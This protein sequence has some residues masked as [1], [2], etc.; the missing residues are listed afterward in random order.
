MKY[1]N[2]LLV[3]TVATACAAES[4]PA[5]TQTSQHHTFR[6]V[7]VVEG[8]EN[9]WGMAFL[10]DG[11]LLVTER[12]GNLRI[13]DTENNLSDPIEGVPEVLAQGQGGMLGVYVTEPTRS[14]TPGPLEAIQ[15]SV[16]RNIEFSGLIFRTL[17]G[18]FVAY[19]RDRLG[20]KSEITYR[21]LNSEVSR[22]W[23][24]N[25]AE[26]SVVDDSGEITVYGTDERPIA[27]GSWSGA[28]YDGSEGS[29]E[30]LAACE[31]TGEGHGQLAGIGRL[32]RGAWHRAR[33]INSVMMLCGHYDNSGEFAFRVGLPGKSGVGGGILAIAPGH[34]AIA[35]WSPGLNAAG[36]SD[37]VIIYAGMR[38]GGRVLYAFDVTTPTAPKFLWRKTNTDLPALGRLGAHAQPGRAGGD[39]PDPAGGRADPD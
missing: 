17:G 39:E 36:T 13:L 25:R 18:L 3:L 8:L 9:P 7:N 6:H 16:E 31:A 23:D 38:R 10:P 24:W 35:V 32:G 12:A 1:A 21:V 5:Q 34:G 4:V 30:A 14:F 26:A 11:R 20:Y 27:F 22:G 37:K 15:L 33:R 19:A 2:L 29:E 28:F